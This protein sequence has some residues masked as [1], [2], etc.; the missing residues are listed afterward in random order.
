MFYCKAKL[1]NV[2]LDMQPI[3]YSTATAQNPRCSFALVA[4]VKDWIIF[5]RVLSSTLSNSDLS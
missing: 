4:Q 1:E 2:T 5:F 3:V